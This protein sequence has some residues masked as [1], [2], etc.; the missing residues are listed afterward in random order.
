[1]SAEATTPPD[2]PSVR[3]GDEVAGQVSR[4]DPFEPSIG[5]DA[6]AGRCSV[7]AHRLFDG[8]VDLGSE[9]CA[10]VRPSMTRCSLTTMQVSQPALRT[11]SRTSGSGSSSMQVGTSVCATSQAICSGTFVASCGSPYEPQVFLRR[12]TLSRP[13][14]RNTRATS[15]RFGNGEQRAGTVT[16]PVAASSDTR[17]PA[18]SR[19]PPASAT[20]ARTL[21]AA[22]CAWRS[23]AR[24]IL[25]RAYRR[26]RG[27]IP[28]RASRFAVRR[29]RL[30]RG[31]GGWLAGWLAR[32][33]DA[34]R[35][36]GA[37]APAAAVR[38]R[39][40]PAR[41]AWRSRARPA[42]RSRARFRVR[43]DPVD[44]GAGVPQARERRRGGA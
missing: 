43:R 13:R 2:E 28:R 17:S 11:R 37:R 26:R 39:P 44:A 21:C 33:L 24:A 19:F 22:D 6:G 31:N 18:S 34:L 9:R 8:F 5:A 4:A 27:G 14:S 30:E 20:A 32:R 1:M 25:G 36:R 35:Q 16:A 29:R 10:T 12:H 40:T 23:E 42:R 38:G 15:A 7:R 41:R 3:G